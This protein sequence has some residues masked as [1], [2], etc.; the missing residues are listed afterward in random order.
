MTKHTDPRGITFECDGCDDELLETGTHDWE[1]ARA[2]LKDAMWKTEK[3]EA[4]WLHLCG[5][6]RLK[7]RGK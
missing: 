1:Q 6:C 7:G 2:Q 3:V 4:E 5:V